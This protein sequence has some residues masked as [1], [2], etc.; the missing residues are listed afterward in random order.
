MAAPQLVVASP[1]T[2]A[3]LVSRLPAE[4]RAR[5]AWT[6]KRIADM[7]T[8]LLQEPM[9]SDGIIEAAGDAY[10]EA[11]RALSPALVGLARG[12]RELA[13]VVER[14]IESDWRLMGSLSG[15]NQKAA[16][17]AMATLLTL[18]HVGAN[19][20]AGLDVEAL[21]RAVAAIDEGEAEQE[22]TLCR[23]AALSTAMLEGLRRGSPVPGRVAALAR[24]ADAAAHELA[25][26]LA[27]GEPRLLL[28]WYLQGAPDAEAAAS[29]ASWNPAN[30][31]SVLRRAGVSDSQAELEAWERVKAGVDASRPHRKLF[32]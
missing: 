25:L 3:E 26:A 30:R 23:A 1:A 31:T 16:Q 32:S 21:H 6:P 2:L 28:P 18:A 12:A 24:R 4:A 19:A 27:T 14:G 7:A 10:F 11:V 17:R 8:M 5:V 29:F 13:E 15:A 9:L 20:L 22:M